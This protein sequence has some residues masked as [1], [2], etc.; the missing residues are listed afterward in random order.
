MLVDKYRQ[1]D[2]IEVDHVSRICRLY[3]KEKLPNDFGTSDD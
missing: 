3:G 1:C 2:E